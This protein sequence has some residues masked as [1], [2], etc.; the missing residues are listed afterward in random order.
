VFSSSISTARPLIASAK[1]QDVFEKE[2]YIRECSQ[3]DSIFLTLHL[4]M[5]MVQRR[6]IIAE[7]Q[8]GL[9]LTTWST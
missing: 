4:T 9:R 5:S 8:V 6:T 3:L 1:M 2:H 7:Q